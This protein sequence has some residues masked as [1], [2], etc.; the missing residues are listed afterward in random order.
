MNASRTS[1]ICATEKEFSAT[2]LGLVVSDR[3]MDG[4]SI[5]APDADVP[6]ERALS[7]TIA[8][9]ARVTVAPSPFASSSISSSS[10]TVPI[11][12]VARPESVATD[13]L[14]VRVVELIKS[15]ELKEKPPAAQ[16][17]GAAA[18]SM[19]TR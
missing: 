8:V 17:V 4:L 18:R 12:T 15:P 9:T 11:V 7:P 14:D 13:E 5:P 1:H 10:V 3:R 6:S 2:R 19:R 16:L